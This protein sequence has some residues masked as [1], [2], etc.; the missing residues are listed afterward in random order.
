MYSVSN[1]VLEKAF[2]RWG[3]LSKDLNE[4][5]DKPGSAGEGVLQAEGTAEVETCLSAR[6][7]EN[8]KGMRM[9]R[10]AGTRSGRANTRSLDHV[11]RVMG[12]HWRIWIG[13]QMI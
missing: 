13:T 4:V 3:L 8:S 1:T 12:S 2:L 6:W 9:E 11:L 10:Q 7:Q 5:A